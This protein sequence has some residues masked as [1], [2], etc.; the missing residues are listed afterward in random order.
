M[1]LRRDKIV[2]GLLASALFGVLLLF[3]IFG[4][5]LWRESVVAEEA[6]LGDLAQRLGLQAE[7]AIIDARDLLE[8]LN[9]SPYPRCSPQ[10]IRLMQEETFARP[11]IRAI[12]YWRAVERL[13]GTGFA[14][15]AALRPPQASRIYDNGLIA[16]WPGPDTT[17]GGVPLFLMRFGNHDIAIDPRQLLNAGPLS[18]QRVGL[19]VEGLAMTRIPAE[20]ELPEPGSLRRGLTVD[21]IGQRVSSRFSLGTIFSIDI[22]AMQPLSE[23]WN[24]YLPTLLLAGALGLLLLALWVFVVLSFSRRHLSL[25]AEL[26]NAIER[27]EIVLHYQP[28][29]DLANG[30]CNG[31]EALARW[32]RENGDAVSPDVFV[33]MAE[34][35]G[36]ITDLTLAV[37]DLVLR[38]LG[39]LLQADPGIAINI[40]L[41]AQDLESE[42]LPLALES[43]LREAGLPASAIK[44]ELTERALLDN[45]LPRR[46]ISQLRQQGHAVA[47]DDFGTGYSSLSYLESFELDI[48][49]IDKAFVDTIET[50]A[51]TGTVIGHVIEMAKSLQLDIVAEGIESQ[52]QVAWLAQQ[53]VRYGQGYYF[54]RP[55]APGDFSSWLKSQA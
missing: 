22:V 23:F 45:E 46:R 9:E 31:A 26:R 7:S 27:R 53:G 52:H 55:M 37:L 2:V 11:H 40:N 24:R 33:P 17:V 21:R 29:V 14:E 8:A 47:I 43:G 19:W 44:L 51:V 38:D 49:K 34:K 54:S 32:T 39:A 1:L 5:Y 18:D 35:A 6:R 30:R 15:G 10:H 25:T 20:S 36:M 41:S 3:S 28:I 48:L 50:H 4:W 12:G 42:R 16:W 13:C